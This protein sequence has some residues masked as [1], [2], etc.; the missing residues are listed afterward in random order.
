M[1]RTPF[2]RRTYE[3]PRHL[4]GDLFRVARDGGLALAVARGRA[5]PAD[6]RER[7]MLAVTQVNGC[8]Y[9]TWLH[10]RVA[11]GVGV[12]SEQVDALLQGE[13][14]DTP[15]DE[16]EALVYA[17]HWA[18]SGGRPDPDLQ[19]RVEQRYG[20]ELTRAIEMSMQ[21]IQVGN[22]FGNTVDYGLY[23][24]SRGHLGDP[25]RT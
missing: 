21:L 19:E 18:E 22:L 12:S 25:A 7:L 6:F 11:R 23:R 24:I 10:S 16:R 15:E 4:A 3:G 8:R 13:L 1:A 14:A 20:L 9:C 17:L 5:L 2:R